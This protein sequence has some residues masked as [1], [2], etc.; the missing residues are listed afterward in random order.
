M[1][2]V[3]DVNIPLVSEV[4]SDFGEVQTLSGRS[5]TAA[6][7]RD[8]EILLVR[9][10]TRVDESLLKDSKVR[11]VGT[12]TIGVDHIDTQFLRNSSIG[13]AYAA[14]S[15]ADSA[16]QYVVSALIEYSKSHNVNLADKTLAIIGVG[17]VGS[18]VLKAAQI[19]GMK[20]LLC[21]PP[22]K[23]LTGSD[24]YL[25]LPEALSEADF[26][27]I[28]VPLEYD[29]SD[30]TYHLISDQAFSF[31]KEGAVFI[32][33]S[34]GKVVDESAL[35]SAC[36]KLG[37]MILDVWYNE[38][39]INRDLI[40]LATIATPHIAGYS[41]RGKRL[42]TRMIYDSACAYFFAENKWQEHA[43]D[44]VNPC[45]IVDV[46]GSL[47]PLYDAISQTYP[48][49]R[50]D[51]TLRK[52]A[53]ISQ[54]KVGDYFDGLRKNYPHRDEFSE[55]EVRCKVGSCDQGALD[56]LGALGFNHS[57]IA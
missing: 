19:L 11:F 21:D 49:M 23:R 54:E 46:T 4:F 53:Q 57:K 20:C 50:D 29:G 27:T 22:K 15:N 5:I 38:P 33:T 41:A 52:G 44:V 14:G 17:N 43:A 8:A 39:N 16:S 30:S 55:R 47:D 7:L 34:R 31:V 35:L 36:G 25:S 13:F 1:K 26:I 48:I 10:V 40:R 24:L 37:G 3:A 56:V 9:S 12:A 51:A 32:N 2:I 45:T 42:G 28:H 18:R 6:H